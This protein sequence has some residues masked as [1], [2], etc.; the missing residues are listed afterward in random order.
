[1]LDYHKKS[2]NYIWNMWIH[3]LLRNL[4]HHFVRRIQAADPAYLAT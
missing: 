3:L 1:M 2:S 4:D